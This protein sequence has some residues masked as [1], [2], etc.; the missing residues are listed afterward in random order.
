M[1]ATASAPGGSGA[2]CRLLDSSVIVGYL[3]NDVPDLAE[4]AR[5]LIDSD[6]P[7]GITTVALLEAAHVLRGPPY[8]Q[9]REAVVDALVGL[10]QRENVLGIG[11]DTAEAAAALLLCRGSSTVSLGDALIAASGRSAGIYGAYSFDARFGRAGVRI[12]PVPAAGEPES[13]PAQP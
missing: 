10:V 8:C 13:G 5:R 3:T 1:P 11:V 2:A 4:Q 9:P 12:V 7:L 6:A